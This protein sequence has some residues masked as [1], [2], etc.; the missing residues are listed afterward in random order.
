MIVRGG[1]SYKGHADE[2]V[3]IPHPGGD[4]RD[5]ATIIVEDTISAHAQH[6]GP[7][8]REPLGC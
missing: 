3:Q 7:S 4:Q 6:N 5:N 8:Y 2:V 1:S